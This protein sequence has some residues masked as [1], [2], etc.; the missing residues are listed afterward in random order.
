MPHLP[1]SLDV[2]LCHYDHARRGTEQPL[3]A[4]TLAELWWKCLE[5]LR[6]LFGTFMEGANRLSSAEP[7]S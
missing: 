4:T 5:M 1:Q 2:V 7:Q 6:V 3:I